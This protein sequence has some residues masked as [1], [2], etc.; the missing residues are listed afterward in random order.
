M[1][2]RQ[3]L[4]VLMV[5]KLN[6]SISGTNKESKSFY[7]SGPD[8]N[9]L[10]KAERESPASVHWASKSPQSQYIGYLNIKGAAG[11]RGR[12]QIHRNIKKIKCFG[13][14]FDIIFSHAMLAIFGRDTKEAISLGKLWIKVKQ[15]KYRCYSTLG[16]SGTLER[17]ISHKRKAWLFVFLCSNLKFLLISSCLSV[18]IWDILSNHAL[19]FTGVMV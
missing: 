16:L 10:K 15:G 12:I 6:I 7:L 4:P 11:P 8:I 17:W 9:T 18:L 5:L 1:E 14:R 3:V 19:I 13:R 2:G